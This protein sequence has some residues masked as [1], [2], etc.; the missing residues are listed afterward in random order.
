MQVNN[1]SNS[2]PL[3]IADNS[4]SIQM[5]IRMLNIRLCQP[6]SD[7]L[8]YLDIV[9]VCIIKTGS[10]DKYDAV[11]FFGGMLDNDGLDLSGT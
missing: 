7:T 4:L 5:S 2:H 11:V 1:P 9:N 6:I 8:Q 3:T 10:T